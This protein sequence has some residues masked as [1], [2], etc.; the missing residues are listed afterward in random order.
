MC[1]LACGLFGKLPAH[2]DFVRRG[3]RSGF[4]RPWDDWLCGLLGAGGLAA[5]LL[6]LRFHLPSGACGAE[7]AAG[8]LLPSADA[9]GRAFP[10]TLAALGVAGGPPP[11]DWYAALE[12]LGAAALEETLAAD[13][14]MARLPPLPSVLPGDIPAECRFWRGEAMAWAGTA[15]PGA[16]CLATPGAPLR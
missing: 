15:L 1:A 12:A 10:L 5:G 7:T 4:V 16:G 9:V 6:P 13:A 3:L 8:V 2:G 14:V 11:H